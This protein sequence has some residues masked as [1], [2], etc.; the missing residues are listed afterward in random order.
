M[1]KKIIV[2]VLSLC[3]Y[4]SF[5]QDLKPVDYVNTLM[6]T[7]SKHSLSNGNTYP[8]VGLPWGMNLWTPQT[9]KM[10]DGWAYTYDADKIKGFKQTHQP[11][12][13]MNDYG[14]FAIMP[15]VGKPKFKEEE[16]ASWFSH[17]AEV[18]TPYSYSV[19]LADADV[20]TELT[21]TERAAYFKFD[22]PKTDSA[23]VVIDALDKGSYIKI[24]PKE[25][26]I[27]GYTTRYAAGKYEN[28]KN[29]FVVQFDKDFDLTSAWKDT[30]LVNDQLEITSNH[31][32]AIV[33]FK[34]KAKESVYAKVASS[35]ISFE[36]AE[37]NLKREI[38]SQSFTQVKSNAKDIWSKTLGKIEVKGGTDEQYRTFYSAMYRTLF[39]P[40]KIY[41]IDAQNK[42]KHWSPYNGKIL[43]GRMFAGTGFW[44]TFRALYPFLNLVYPSINAEMQEGLANAFKEGGFLPEW[45]SPGFADVMIGNNSASVVAD[46]YIKGLRGYDIETLW[47]AVVHGANNEGPMDAVGRR[48]VSYYNSLGYV[49]YDVQINENAARTLEYAYD[50]FA[51]YQLGKALGK[52]ESEIGIF[53]K[54][55]YN[56]KNVFDTSTGMMRGKNKDG[57]FQSPF[58]PFKWGDAFTEGNSWHYTW[59]VFQDIDGLSKLMGGKKKFEAKLDEVFSLPPVFDDSYYG[60]VIHEIR[61]M[62][63]MNMGQYAHGNQP[64]QHM[65]YLYNYA[66]A[67]YKTQYWTRQVINKLYKPTPDGYCGDEDNGQT[68][69]W[70]VFSALGF[71]P[72]T[73]A[74][75]QYVLGAPLFKEATIHLENGKKIEIKAPQNSQENIY[76]ESLKV[77]N[78]PYSKN[79]LNHQEL[80]K[81]AVLNFDMKAQPNKER[82]SQEKDFPYSMSTEK[83]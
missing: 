4:F 78:Q 81:G 80:M 7:Q 48:G 68:S 3:S 27:I 46:A 83:L 10:G 64:I 70:Y 58:N 56:Y 74:T 9:G 1:R 41:E 39:F 60:S 75:N 6:G 18:A 23:Y 52:P 37:I 2:T 44:D 53:K 71:Y 49:P 11:S 30:A 65:I 59:S 55:A 34:L 36:Q 76:V 47:K 14:A 38:G 31:A 12:P 63:I 5:G 66:G 25:K 45:S 61:E 69:A 22:F 21:P 79:W 16:R 19:Y 17:K 51:I 82:G 15:G 40:Q 20:T 62:Q 77:N 57:K 29:Y 67:P 33:G 8:A 54:R 26:K 50:D 13:W 73:P 28:F 35:F 32:G 72:V 24:L 43:D 42:I